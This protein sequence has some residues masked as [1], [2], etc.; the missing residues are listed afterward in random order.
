MLRIYD[1]LPEGFLQAR[2]RQ[3]EQVLGGP[4]L[5]HLPGLRQAP[6]FVSVLLHGNETTGI[7]AIQAVL[8]HY[9]QRPLP[10]ALSLFVGNVSAARHG[11]R[12]LD[13]QP[14]YNRIWPG[15][16][17]PDCPEARM[18]AEVVEIMRRRRV[19]AS[20]DVHNNT[21]LNPHYGCINRLEGPFL[22][23][24]SLFAHTIVYFIRPR[25]VQSL[26]FAELCPAVTL[27][28]GQAGS[29]LGAE[30]ARDL[31]EAG[32]HL[33]EI[34]DHPATAELG[35]YHT[36]AT[37]RVAEGCSFGFGD[38]SAQLR[39][40]EDLEQLNFHELPTGTALARV[41]AD[42][43]SCIRVEDEQ[44]RDA[45]SRY[46]RVEAGEVRTRRHVMPAM[47]THDLRVIRQDCL[48]YFMERLPLDQPVVS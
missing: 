34:P 19:F 36:V 44:G 13:G 37:L 16:D 25:G 3:L 38:D 7:D 32:L 24:A 8:R 17:P 2:P 9:R 29:A 45:T 43:E 31:I 41:S 4:S 6:L 10:R 40:L 47:F 22:Y 35:V 30:H 15:G 39:L 23:L 21:G 42:C 12:R 18:A 26:A 48:G 1:R 5:I 28:C 46:L 11:L 20:I 14:D 33:A 27:E